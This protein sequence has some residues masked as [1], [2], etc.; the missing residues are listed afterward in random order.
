[1][2]LGISAARP[3]PFGVHTRYNTFA[4]LGL[5]FINPYQ[6][7]LCART[8]PIRDICPCDLTPAKELIIDQTP[9]TSDAVIAALPFKSCAL[10]TC[11]LNLTRCQ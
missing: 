6:S 10:V 2:R 5:I 4:D 8:W 7:V 9:F 3:L 11:L 1:M